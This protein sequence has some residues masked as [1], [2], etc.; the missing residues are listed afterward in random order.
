MTPLSARFHRRLPAWPTPDKERV[1][2]TR[3]QT[4]RLQADTNPQTHRR[5]DA[6]SMR[7][8]R[9]RELT[10]AVFEVLLPLPHEQIPM[11]ERRPG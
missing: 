2:E 10:A 11:V 5:G 9:A 7:F 4:N 3:Y 6:D 8:I 1:A